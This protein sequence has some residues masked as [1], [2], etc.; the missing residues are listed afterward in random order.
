MGNKYISVAVVIIIFLLYYNLKTL[1][2]L[3]ELGN[4]ERRRILAFQHVLSDKLEI[5]ELEIKEKDLLLAKIEANTHAFNGTDCMR[6]HVIES[7]LRLPINNNLLTF[8]EFRE[9]VR[10]GSNLMPAYKDTAGRSRNEITDVELR[11]I[12]KIIKEFSDKYY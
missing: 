2:S 5:K 8:N 4:I 12:Y 6:C 1:R 3:E 11:R 7:N 9:K 10:V